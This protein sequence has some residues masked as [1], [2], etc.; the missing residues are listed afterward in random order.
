MSLGQTESGHEIAK[1]RCLR[2]RYRVDTGGESA[3]YQEGATSQWQS[4]LCHPF[5]S[6]FCINPQM[7]RNH[8]YFMWQGN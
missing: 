8:L 3:V 7:I 6:V 2:T 4:A 1:G 5:L